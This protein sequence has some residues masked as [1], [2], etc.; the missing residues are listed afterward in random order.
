MLLRRRNVAPPEPYDVRCWLATHPHAPSAGTSSS[1]ADRLD[2]TTFGNTRVNAAAPHASMQLKQAPLPLPHSVATPSEAP[3]SARI[4]SSGGRP[5]QRVH[6]P[7]SPDH[8]YSKQPNPPL[9]GGFAS[10]AQ[11]HLL[12][13]AYSDTAEHAASHANDEMHSPTDTQQLQHKRLDA[14]QPTVSSWE[15]VLRFPKRAFVIASETDWHESDADML[16]NAPALALDLLYSDATEYFCG[17]QKSP[18]AHSVAIALLALPLSQKQAADFEE[19]LYIVPLARTQHANTDFTTAAVQ[20]MFLNRSAESPIV[21]LRASTVLNQLPIRSNNGG[22]P[23]LCLQTLLS[24]MQGF[25]HLDTT[26]MNITSLAQKATKW[27]NDSHPSW[28][29]LEQARSDLDMLAKI[30]DYMCASVLH[31][32]DSGNHNYGC[33]TSNYLSPLFSALQQVSAVHTAPF[34]G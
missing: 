11:S 8:A 20:D 23:V 25:Q 14:A 17:L 12:S 22:V 13:R 27:F 24:Q 34:A 30:T 32:E 29:V 31:S 2:I 5:S 16:I 15:D 28:G 7:S 1:S 10:H 26:N 33:K 9:A 18:D 4:G 19:A 3:Q 21:L 6:A